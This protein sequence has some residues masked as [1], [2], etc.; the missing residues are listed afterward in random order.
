MDSAVANA[1]LAITDGTLRF[2]LITRPWQLVGW[3]PQRADLKGGGVRRGSPLSDGTRLVDFSYANVIDTFTLKAMHGEQ[4]G[5]I[6]TRQ[7]LDRLLEKGRRYWV[8]DWATEPVW[9]EARGSDETNTRYATIKD[10]RMPMDDNPYAQPFFPLQQEAVMEG[11]V[12]TLEHDFWQANEPGTGTDTE[13]SAQQDYNAVTYGRA[14]TTDEEVYVANRHN[15][16]N[17]THIFTWT[18]PAGPFGG[19]LIG[20]GLPFDIFNGGAGG[21]ANG[22]ITYF[23][24]NTALADSGP[25]SSLVFDILTAATYGAGDSVAWEYWNGAWVAL[26]PLVD[27]TSSNECDED[28]SFENTGVN[29]IHWEQPSDWAAVAVNAITGYWVRLV[30]TEATGITRAQQQN[31][32][33][34]SVVWPEVSIDGA[35]VL[36]DIPALL[37][38][39]AEGMSECTALSNTGGYI[40]RIMVGVRSASR[41]AAASPFR[42]FLNFADEQNPT[43]V[44][45]TAD[46]GA[47]FA[48]NLEAPSGRCLAWAPAGIAAMAERAHI[49]FANTAGATYAGSFHAFLRY[50]VTSGSDGDIR[51]FTHLETDAGKETTQTDVVDLL[52]GTAWNVVPL[53][54][55]HLPALP[56]I[57]PGLIRNW[58]FYVSMQNTVAAARTINLFDLILM[59]ADEW[60][61]D[62]QENITPSSN[63]GFPLSTHYYLD[64]DPISLPKRLTSWVIFDTFGNADG[65]MISYTA[66]SPIL[67]AN[68]DQRLYFF[69][70]RN[71]SLTTIPRVAEPYLSMR[72]WASHTDRYQSMRGAR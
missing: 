2:S 61:G 57:Q 63:T 29:S 64:V 16:A 52:A 47:A 1:I 38:F 8:D 12:L 28:E 30:V 23:G 72:V 67:Q 31:R 50:Q 40:N 69:M 56:I 15:E 14:A 22:D 24:I 17:V 11:L 66:A 48:N 10:W 71:P 26:T 18:S 32:D 13:I 53:G 42:A 70:S 35:I 37:N 58:A 59:P 9:I 60:L 25:F 45:A 46:G 68:A 39:K 49:T 54:L 44:T 62:F 19:N 4:D 3:T 36:G 41:D 27:N 7:E 5:T 51:L 55:L 34:Y 33:I 43:L 65:L 20:A 6:R 21:P